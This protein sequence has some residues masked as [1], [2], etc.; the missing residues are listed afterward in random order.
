MCLGS[1]F[2]VRTSGTTPDDLS[3]SLGDI[4]HLT[5]THEDWWRG[6]IPGVDGQRMCVCVCVCVCMCMCACGG[7]YVFCVPGGGVSMYVV[8]PVWCV[9]VDER[10]WMADMCLGV[11]TR[12]D[13]SL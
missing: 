4:I 2:R 9:C 13:I 3:F 11:C 10:G 8:W 5:H 6:E 1:H 12:H 7:W